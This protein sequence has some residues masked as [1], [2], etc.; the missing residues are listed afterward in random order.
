MHISSDK[1]ISTLNRLGIEHADFPNSGNWLDTLCKF[2]FDRNLGAAFIN[3]DTSVF[4]CYS[5][6]ATTNLIGIVKHV[7]NIEYASACEFIGVERQSYP[8]ARNEPQEQV[9]DALEEVKSKINY[10]L[11]LIDFDPT[12]IEYTNQ[13]GWT[14]E[15]V[16][17][18]NIKFCN[19]G[20]YNGYA[21]IPI[22]EA[23]TFEARKLNEK[24]L[25]ITFF[26]IDEKL[27]NIMSLPRLRAKFKQWCKDNKDL[28][29]QVL[30]KE[31]INW[32]L[33]NL[34]KGKTLYPSDSLRKKPCIFNQ[35]K[36]DRNSD[37][38]LREGVSGIA[39][40]WTSISKNVSATF[41]SEISKKQFEVLSQFKRKIL[42]IDNDIAGMKMLKS[43]VYNVPEI[44]VIQIDGEDTD[45][46]YIDKVK[47]ATIQDG[48]QFYLNSLEIFNKERIYP[49][50]KI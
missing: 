36:L 7:Q 8:G 44:Y 3:L 9:N 26:K 48:A 20:F 43:L 47:N 29:N 49:E 4:H 2:H 21:I 14:T 11:S 50:Y 23:Q 22:S 45:V 46:D 42:I 30:K 6:G 16:D 24:D 5:C 33:K 32:E 25:L 37:L 28:V 35:D 17:C 10:N 13:R 34:L 38:Y 19:S 18:F 40:I 12:S 39:K 15:F 27:A 1:I 41:G 31:V